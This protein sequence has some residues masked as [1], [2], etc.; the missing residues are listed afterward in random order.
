[1][2]VVGSIDEQELDAAGQE[3][4]TEAEN[5]AAV[6]RSEPFVVGIGASAGGLEALQVFVRNLTAGGRLSYVVAQ[7]LS[8]HHRSMLIELLARETTLPVKEVTRAQRP[9]PDPIYVTPPNKHIEFQDGILVIRTPKLKTGPQPS[10]DIFFASLALELEDHAIGIIFSGTGSDGARGIR[11]I[12]AAGGITC[13]H[14]ESAKYNGMPRAAI[15]TGSVDY[16]LS[17]A[18]IAERL[19]EMLD[20]SAIVPLQAGKDLPP[21]AFEEIISVIRT[22]T[23]IDFADYRHSTILRRVSRRMKTTHIDSLE[24]YAEVLKGSPEEARELAAEL[25]IGVTSFFRDAEAYRALKELV[26]ILVRSKGE[27]EPIRIW[28]PACS[29]GEEAYSIAIL[30]LE[31]FRKIG[32]LPRLQLFATDLDESALAQARRGLY[33]AA[34]LESIDRGHLKR[35]F[36]ELGQNFQVNGEVRDLIVFSKHNLIEDPPFSKLDL[37]SCRNLFIYF[38]AILQRRILERLHYGLRQGGYLFL[39]KSESIG[40]RQDLF[41]THDSSAKIYRA[42]TGVPTSYRPVAVN[43]G[44]EPPTVLQPRPDVGRRKRESGCH[45][46]IS[47]CLGPPSVVVNSS[48]KPLYVGSRIAPYLQVPTGASDFDIFSLVSTEV[49]AELRAMMAHSR[50]E[51]VIVRSRVHVAEHE[52]DRWN[53]RLEVH[54]FEQGDTGEELTVIGFIPVRALVEAPADEETVDIEPAGRSLQFEAMEHELASMREHLQTMVEELETSNEELQALNEELQSSNEELQST[55]E[56]L[57]TSNEEL[58]STNEE[59]TTVN[60]EM[61]VKTQE[62]TEAYAFLENTLES[63]AHPVLVTDPEGHVLRF[64]KSAKAIFEIDESEIGRPITSLRKRHRI[65][66]LGRMIDAALNSGKRR[67]RRVQAGP[68]CYQLHVHACRDG[69]RNLMGA[70]VIFDDITKLV[71]S[72]ARLRDKERELALFSQTQTAILD[73]LPAHVALL[74]KDGRILAVNEEWRRFARDNGYRGED[75]GVGKSYLKA[76]SGVAGDAQRDANEVRKGVQKL[77]SGRIDVMEVRYTCDSPTEKRWFRCVGRAVHADDKRLGAVVMHIN[78]TDQVLAEQSMVEA[79]R[80]AE[81]AN[82]AKSNFL[83][84][85]SHEL[86]TPLNAIIG[87]SEMQMKELFGAQGHPK[88]A[89]YAADVHSEAQHLLS[90][91]DEILDL[92][93]VE[94]GRHEMHEARVDLGECLTFSFKLLEKAAEDR[95][96]GL[97]ADIPMELPPLLADEALIRRML[98]NLLSNSVKFTN[99][100][101][102]IKVSASI[103]GDEQLRLT[104]SDN[105]IGIAQDKL[106]R[107]FEPFSQVRS[108]LTSSQTGVGLGLALVNSMIQ[109]HGGRLEIES[110][111]GAGTRATLCFPP[112]RLIRSDFAE[113]A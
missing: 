72:N 77:L 79:R 49:R 53:Y 47:K 57:E 112:G 45:E 2:C 81:D 50:R 11:S 102:S 6:S 15:S 48:D 61:A 60:E 98:T 4:K 27:G 54:P 67:S 62:L 56:E 28:V 69:G 100:G 8:P 85:M 95:G 19:P 34:S 63:L 21:D 44:L 38:N 75:F 74:D 41:S 93:K 9:Q 78:E 23:K 12:K 55:N 13:A 96:V 73:S 36:T 33:S 64:N 51:K 42:L 25:L 101:G 40:E 113:I 1:M 16:V 88:Y 7:H 66:D 17:P 46:A 91:I 71:D 90:M 92:S 106:K 24:T 107:I 76:C 65:P 14:D 29:T 3:E 103:S 32:G 84:H 68:S 86:R 52:G 39:G 109:M 99:A 5:S 30:F 70:V 111:V 37:I 59:L 104:V 97:Q 58:Q 35:Y 108:T 80:I 82:S 87:F 22:Q 105:G 20:Q 43:G 89:E 110:E 26:E 10:I 18:E 83:A 94:A 31:A